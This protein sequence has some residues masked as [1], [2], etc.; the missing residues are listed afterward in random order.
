MEQLYAEL[1]SRFILYADKIV[2]DAVS[3]LSLDFRLCHTS[4]QLDILLQEGSPLTPVFDRVPL[5]NYAKQLWKGSEPI[6][7]PHS[8]G[9]FRKGALYLKQMGYTWSRISIDW[10]DWQ[11][12]RTVL[13]EVGATPLPYQWIPFNRLD[14]LE[15]VLSHHLRNLDSGRCDIVLTGDAMVYHTLR[16]RGIVSCFP[17]PDAE[18]VQLYLASVLGR[19]QFLNDERYRIAAVLIHISTYSNLE[20]GM[21]FF[22]QENQMSVQKVLLRYAQELEGH[23]I[24]F[25]AEDYL[26]LTTKSI[27][28]AFT[29]EYTTCPL[30][31]EL[32][33]TIHA[34][35]QMGV[36][37]GFTVQQ[38]MQFAQMGLKYAVEQ[39]RSTCYIVSENQKLIGPII[40]SATSP[41]F[42]R[43]NIPAVDHFAKVQG[44]PKESLY[45]FF[46]YIR[47]SG[48][49][50]FSVRE[51]APQLGLSART[52]YRLVDRLI[53]CSYV[54]DLGEVKEQRRGRAAHR[55][56]VL[57]T[58]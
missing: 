15:Q 41:H 28:R 14:Q 38:S 35:V 40:E 18:E 10:P 4:T 25:G 6:C 22:L 12:C 42:S 19:A 34:P 47:K 52:V 45:K 29:R 58:L 39:E 26:F 54:E 23:W 11:P 7:L 1:Q 32:E 2:T 24:A 48:T 33:N 46:S 53:E 50:D 49:L 20:R 5:W 36:G 8:A 17:S 55:Y 31:D 3:S 9:R 13:S 44:V 37:I 56:R 30:L 57:K 51:I 16:N 21:E 43:L 27:F